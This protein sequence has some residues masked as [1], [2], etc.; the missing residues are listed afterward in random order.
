MFFNKKDDATSPKKKT[1]TLAPAFRYPKVKHR[2]KHIFTE[3]SPTFDADIDHYLPE[4][5]PTAHLKVEPEAF[6]LNPDALPPL[7]K[8]V[9]QES[10][11]F[12]LEEDFESSPE[13][14]TNIFLEEDTP[15]FEQ[16][17]SISNI[18]SVEAEPKNPSFLQEEEQAASPVEARFDVSNEGMVDLNTDLSHNVSGLASFEAPPSFQDTPAEAETVYETVLTQD[19]EESSLQSFL[20]DDFVPSPHVA[21]P[22]PEKLTPVE[23][24]TLQARTLAFEDEDHYYNPL[25]IGEVLPSYSLAD[26]QTQNAVDTKELDVFDDLQDADSDL[27]ESFAVAQKSSEAVAVVF[28]GTSSAP[29]LEVEQAFVEDAAVL[30]ETEPTMEVVFE[31]DT[32]REA[33]VEDSPETEESPFS[34]LSIEEPPSLSALDASLDSPLETSLDTSLDASLNA[35]L[36]S[37]FTEDIFQI[38]ELPETRVAPEEPPYTPVNENTFDFSVF[39]DDHPEANHASPSIEAH[40]IEALFSPSPSPNT[41]QEINQDAPQSILQEDLVPEEHI[42]FP[43]ESLESLEVS[44]FP[45]ENHLI[46]EDDDDLQFTAEPF[47][48]PQVD[49]DFLALEESLETLSDANLELASSGVG[50]PLSD[51]FSQNDVLGV[52]PEALPLD[53][54]SQDED[55]PFETLPPEVSSLETTAPTLSYESFRQLEEGDDALDETEA[56]SPNHFVV[57]SDAVLEDPNAFLDPSLFFSLDGLE[58]GTAPE[59]LS[60]DLEPLPDFETLAPLPDSL[61]VASTELNMLEAI[62]HEQTPQLLHPLDEA[63]A[64]DEFAAYFPEK[65]TNEATLGEYASLALEDLDVLVTQAFPHGESR[66]YLVH[67]NDV[68]AIIALKQHKYS[69]LQSF[70]SLP[71][72]VELSETSEAQQLKE[73]SLQLTWNASSYDEHI[74]DVRLGDWH[75]LIVEDG[76][77]ITL[78]T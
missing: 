51:D 21:K 47:A 46:I 63:E 68:F 76:K 53:A 72:G 39:L 22:A 45:T 2:E 9:V 36:D 23:E 69:L 34:F 14:I 67:V 65:E 77:G 35:S 55:D 13:L 8:P 28:G 38:P 52:L 40:N 17:P 6:N 66:L 31:A 64:E 58:D 19:V 78:L 33:P 57:E 37:V 4:Y 74:F 70:S 12:S 62:D 25:A 24:P 18:F 10:P 56:S 50:I 29:V 75:A 59:A 5:N 43:A 44:D 1:N 73:G 61:P 3:N 42:E 26:T 15:A 41:T 27:Q 54:F 16:E 71:E 60:M 11:I 49:S 20:E 30:D 7:H 48:S 32:S